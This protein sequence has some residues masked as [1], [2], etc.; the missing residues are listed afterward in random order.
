MKLKA[1]VTAL[2]GFATD[3]RFGARLLARYPGFTAV[4]ILVL[5]LGIGATSSIFSLVNSV[6]V[7]PLPYANPGE[8]VFVWES[9]RGPGASGDRR[10]ASYP[11]FQDWRRTSCSF[12]HLSGFVNPTLTLSDAEKNTVERIP[13]EMVSPA[14]FSML[15]IQ[16]V[17]GQTFKEKEDSAPGNARVAVLSYALWQSRFAGDPGILGH[18]I[19][20]N[21]TAF[22]ILGVM[23]EGF[24]GISGKALVWLPMMAYAT[25]IPDLLTYDVAARRDIR[26]HAVV[27]RLASGITLKQASS[28]LGT[29]A[30][31]LSATY[32]DSNTDTGIQIVPMTEQ[33]FGQIKPTLLLLLASVGFVLLIACTNLANLLLARTNSRQQE[34]A[35]RLALGARRGQLIRQLLTESTLLG[36]LGGVLGLLLAI[37]AVRLLVAL[38][39]AEIPSYLRIGVDVWVLAF[40]LVISLV[41]GLAIGLVPALRFS[42]PDLN[43]WIKEES[44]TARMPHRTRSRN[45]LMVAEVALTLLLV[46]GAGLLIKSFQR[47]QSFDPGFQVEER[48]AMR[49]DLPVGKLTDN[50]IVQFGQQLLVDVHAMPAVHSAALVSDLPLDGRQTAIFVF[51]EGYS[52][53]RRDQGVRVYRHLISPGFFSTLGIS[54]VR[55]VDFTPQD[56][57]GTVGVVIISERLANRYWSGQDP[58][59]KRLTLGKPG[60]PQPWLSVIG[61]VRDVHYRTLLDDPNADPDVYFP[62]TQNPTSALAL[63]LHMRGDLGALTEA[64][65]QEVQKLDPDVPLYD[66]STMRQRIAKTT[67]NARFG[68]VLMGLFAAGALTLASIGLYGLVSY[69]VSQRSRA[70]GI[71]IALGANNRQILGLVIREGVILSLVGIGVGLGSAFLLTRALKGLL[72]QVSVSDPAV[73]VTA[74]LVLFL[75]AVLASYFPARRASRVNPSIILKDG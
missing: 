17:H 35:I 14:Y 51:P 47:L 15:G 31:S 62:F 2:R 25:A 20:L 12:K 48:G 36:L 38:L 57:Q 60:S 8:L 71:R 7:Q 40:T 22:T 49:V 33:I 37:G 53:P 18:V 43:T 1:P 52:P 9:V 68:S 58:V 24:S 10:A 66:I 42:R 46:I 54:F 23:P 4:S 55:G 45:V 59:G 72:Y 50:Q 65:R 56:R 13:G 30:Q 34:I 75:V 3:L 67:A 27:G 39:A 29:I 44:A 32:P 11:D 64:L 19:R 61:V 63:V 28:E 41:T 69:S 5:A 6:L 74:P 26:W 70:L 21:G 16:A 73:F